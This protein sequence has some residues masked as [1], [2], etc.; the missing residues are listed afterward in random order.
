[1]KVYDGDTVVVYAQPSNRLY[2]PQYY[3]NKTTFN[4]ADRIGVTGNVTGIDFVLA[5]KPV[6]PNGISGVI[7]DTNRV[8]VKSHVEA[9]RL[10]SATATDARYAVVSDSLG[11]YAFTNLLPGKYILLAIPH[12][13]LRA[14]Y[15]K[16]DGTTTM[17]WR[18]AD[19]VMVDSASLV[20][21]INFHVKPTSD[22]GH[23]CIHG[24]V[25]NG[26][27]KG[28]TVGSIVSIVDANN[29]IASFAIVDKNGKYV[30][31]GLTAGSYTV[32]ADYV[33]F[34]TSSTSSVAIDYSAN[35]MKQQDLTIVPFTATEVK[36]DVSTVS[37][38][39]LYQN[40]PNPFNPTTMIRFTLAEK[41]NVKLTVYDMMGREVAQLIN[42]VTEA[43]SHSVE[44]N[45]SGFASGV[46]FY[47]LTGADL[48]ITRKLV[49]L[50]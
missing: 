11:Q 48:S 35:I 2:L 37:G 19:S 12:G 17:N 21:G 5:L 47:T 4:E 45:A 36:S 15:F 23:G 31:D 38:Y 13:R 39:A 16:Y 40:Y 44:F 46:Y 18:N 42:G 25:R 32:S 28:S 34:Q 50:K 20:T 30:V 9:Y 8:G 33:N 26:G 43:G 24:Y 49:I 1:V 22:T 29:Q 41:T 14:T 6:Y 10:K 3:N 27:G 7:T